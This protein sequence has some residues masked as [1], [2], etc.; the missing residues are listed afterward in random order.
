MYV[1]LF[2]VSG[3]S[4][5]TH[6]N[7]NHLFYYLFTHKKI[8]HIINFAVNFSQNWHLP[9]DKTKMVSV[10]HLEEIREIKLAIYWYC[11]GKIDTFLFFTRSRWTLFGIYDR[12]FLLP[13]TWRRW[14]IKW[15][16]FGHL[17]S[18]SW[19]YDAHKD[20]SKIFFFKNTF[21]NSNRF[22]V[23]WNN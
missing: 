8:S 10:A 6:N 20:A 2:G 1:E 21:T 23:S 22:F 18:N 17:G 5:W 7:S 15:M 14:K 12:I 13:S 9:S 11:L 19:K 16:F 4:P 3:V